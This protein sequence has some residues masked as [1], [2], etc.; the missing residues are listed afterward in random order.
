MAL[1]TQTGTAAIS[2]REPSAGDTTAM[3]AMT[4]LFFTCGFLATLNDVLIPHLKLIFDLTY[5]EVMLTQ[6]SFFSSFLI[7]AYPFGKVVARFGYQKTLV[8]GL[9]MM[10][11]GALL[12][13]PAA[14][15]P[16]F[17]FFMG[18]LVVLAGGIT[19]LQVSGNPYVALLGPPQ[20]ASSRLNLAQAFNSLG[21]TIA[22]SIGGALILGGGAH[23]TAQDVRKLSGAA[24]QSFRMQQASYVKGPYVA[25]ASTL[26]LLGCF[27]AWLK[28][29]R[30]EAVQINPEQGEAGRSVWTYP[31][32]V[33]GIGAMFLYCGAEITI[34]SFLVSYLSQPA[35]GAMTQRAAAGLVSIYWGGSMLG[36]FGGSALLRTVDTG[37]LLAIHA[38]AALVLVTISMGAH[39][40]LAVGA[41]LLV[42]L[43]NSIM[44][45][46]VFTLGIAGLGQL[47]GKASG[48]LMSAAVGAAVIPVLQGALADRIGVQYSFAVPAFCY[49]CM[50]FYGW[51]GC[52]RA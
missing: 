38:I 47:T 4:A 41:I 37:K 52:E 40:K 39:G 10:C 11:V 24:L 32:L 8:S 13:L 12:F 33:F 18:A 49:A 9:W 19:G 21:S 1:Q 26:L 2:R 6:F 29:P 3:V 31:Q 30:A 7:F 28:L 35:I 5:A 43:C 15:V 44:F 46:S 16:S 48:I 22:P 25:I 42:G 50:A 20:T 27:V 23:L 17:W 34:G 14:S 36:R 51:K 45:P